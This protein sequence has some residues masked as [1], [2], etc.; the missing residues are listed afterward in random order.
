MLQRKSRQMA[1]WHV[2]IEWDFYNIFKRQSK[3]KRTLTQ[4][5]RRLEQKMHLK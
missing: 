5:E 4:C 3:E 1:I 2:L